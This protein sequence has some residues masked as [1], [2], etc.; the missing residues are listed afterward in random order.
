MSLKRCL[1]LSTLQRYN[2]SGKIPKIFSKTSSSCC[3]RAGNLR[4]NAK[5][6]SIS[7]AS[8][9][10]SPS[11]NHSWRYRSSRHRRPAFLSVKSSFSGRLDLNAKRESPLVSRLSLFLLGGWSRNPPRR[12]TRRPK[13]FTSIHNSLRSRPSESPLPQMR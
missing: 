9:L 4:Q 8:L 2:D 1:F 3:D 5:N 7:V 12:S 13:A 11:P 6:A 10:T